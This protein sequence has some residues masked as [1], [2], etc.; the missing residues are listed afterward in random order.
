[1]TVKVTPVKGKVEMVRNPE[2]RY[3]PENTVKGSAADLYGGFS[4]DDI[5]EFVVTARAMGVEGDTAVSISY[6][7]KEF[8]SRY[9]KS[10]YFDVEA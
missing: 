10:L 8:S 7:D 3:T 2:S 1:M 9:L 6:Y 4:L 5:E